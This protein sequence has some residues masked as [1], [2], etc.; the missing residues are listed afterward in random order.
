MTTQVSIGHLTGKGE[1]M[2]KEICDK[3]FGRIPTR[4]MFKPVYGLRN[5]KFIGDVVKVPFTLSDELNQHGDWM[6]DF[7]DAFETMRAEVKRRNNF[8]NSLKSD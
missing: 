7:D 1:T 6:D 4:F 3:V 2:I 8:E 5:G